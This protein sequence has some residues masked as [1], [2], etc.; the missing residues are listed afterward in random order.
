MPRSW[1]W[2]DPR[3]TFTLPMWL[4]VFPNAKVIHVLRD[5]ESVA[6]S[7]MKRN[8]VKGEVHDERLNNFDFNLQLVEKYQLQG[9]SYATIL[10]RHYHEIWYEQLIELDLEVIG[11]LETFTGKELSGAFKYYV[12]S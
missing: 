6:R 10:G 12:K 7:L 3:N 9:K 1:G 4:K 11:K 5:K 2:K 8:Q